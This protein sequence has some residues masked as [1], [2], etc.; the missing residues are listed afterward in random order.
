MEIFD[1]LLTSPLGSE[2]DSRK[3]ERAAV[4][5]E[6]PCFFLLVTTCWRCRILS[7]SF[8]QLLRPEDVQ[9]GCRLPHSPCDLSQMILITGWLL[10]K[11]CGLVGDSQFPIFHRWVEWL[12][13]SLNPFITLY[14]K[15]N[16]VRSGKHIF[17]SHFT[18]FHPLWRI[19]G[20]WFYLHRRSFWHDH[21][22]WLCCYIDCFASLWVSRGCKRQGST[23]QLR[24]AVG[25]FYPWGLLMLADLPEV[26]PLFSVNLMLLEFSWVEKR[27]YEMHRN[28][29]EEVS[30]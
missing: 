28:A 7:F 9:T 6:L 8:F 30:K 25:W 1:T 26:F 15:R 16:K 22:V 17:C 12:F 20:S 29:I 5:W 27:E 21:Y 13:I 14:E 18:F 24:V 4:T 10:G 2:T 19:Q 23:R 3:G 11:N